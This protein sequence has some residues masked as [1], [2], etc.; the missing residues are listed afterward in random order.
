[1]LQRLWVQP[2]P[3]PATLGWLR[4][5]NTGLNSTTYSDVL[6]C[7]P[8]W[9]RITW[10]W[11]LFGGGGLE[12]TPVSPNEKR[13]LN[14]GMFFHQMKAISPGKTTHTSSCPQ[15]G[16]D[17]LAPGL[18][19]LDPRTGPSF[20]LCLSDSPKDVNPL[21][22]ISLVKVLA[23]WCPSGSPQKAGLERCHLLPFPSVAET[24]GRHVYT[25]QFG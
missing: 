3:L 22:S 14:R 8:N 13:T 23:F 15:G 5:P 4:S 7:R 6:I 24:S 16:L 19:P 9:P 1:M 12:S 17:Q 18:P 2:G 10:I 20:P 11:D 21:D 25:L